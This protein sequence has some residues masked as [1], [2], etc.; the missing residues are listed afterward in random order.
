MNKSTTT[1]DFGRLLSLLIAAALVFSVYQVA[2]L[3]NALLTL[4][5][6]LI[7]LT[8]IFGNF[9]FTGG[10][11]AWINRK[12]GRGLRAQMLIIGLASLLFYP[13]LAGGT[14]FGNDVRGFVTPFG[15]STIF[16]SFLFGLGM[17][18]G[19]CCASGALSWA[20]GGSTR[21]LITLTGFIV[22]AV[23]G[24]YDLPFWQSL[25]ALRVDLTNEF[26]V[27]GGLSVTLILCA[28][29]ALVTLGFEKKRHGK[30]LA[31]HDEA[32]L[33]Q[34]WQRLYKGYWP[35]VAVIGLLI[36]ANFLTLAFAGRPWGVTSAF[37]LWGSKALAASGID[38]ST[39]GYWQTAT[40]LDQS[41]FFHITSVM[42]LGILVGSLIAAQM[43]GTFKPVWN[44]APKL[45]IMSLIGGLLLG[46]GSRIAYGCN[47]GAFFSGISSASLSGWIWFVSAFIGNIAGASMKKRF[48]L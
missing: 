20:G 41:I 12:D 22:G 37:A 40:G 42:N 33:S 11:V 38:V 25:P 29:V 15:I 31:F 14:L 34:G 16:G 18:F 21:I 39:W 9:G 6:L 26:G 19:G 5:G 35:V 46:Y 1:S 23:W 8:L 10:W 17:Q 28:L 2:G 24:A 45:I 27:F 43:M 4:V 13:I 44:I 30:I 32:T 7:G 36:L 48:S 47:I 3:N